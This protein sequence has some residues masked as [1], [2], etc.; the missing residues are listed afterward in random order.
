MHSTE[1]LGWVPRCAWGDSAPGQ[2]QGRDLAQEAG[3]LS[4]GV[5]VLVVVALQR[6]WVDPGLCLREVHYSVLR[7]GYEGYKELNKQ[8]CMTGVAHLRA[9]GPK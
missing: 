2:R 4:E 9:A 3:L 6:L 8:R 5:Y 1:C 7:S